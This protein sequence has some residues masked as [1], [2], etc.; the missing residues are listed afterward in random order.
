MVELT[1]TQMMGQRIESLK[2]QAN[3]LEGDLVRINDQIAELDNE[4]NGWSDARLNQIEEDGLFCAMCGAVATP[5]YRDDIGE[6]C[7]AC[8]VGILIPG[9]KMAARMRMENMSCVRNV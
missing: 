2:R 4:R 3:E 8:A 5:G 6:M 1:K 9:A 7:S